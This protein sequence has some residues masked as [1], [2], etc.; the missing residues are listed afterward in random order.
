MPDVASLHKMPANFW[1]LGVLAVK[2][3]AT[4]PL[5]IWINIKEF[6]TAFLESPQGKNWTGIH[7]ALP[8]VCLHGMIV[9][10]VD[11][12]STFS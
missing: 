1:L 3:F 9:P 11:L 7:V 10:F 8:H 2:D 5:D 6:L 12:A 4:N